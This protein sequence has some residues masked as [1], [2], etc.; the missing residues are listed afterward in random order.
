MLLLSPQTVTVFRLAWKFI[1]SEDEKSSKHC[2]L[3]RLIIV[4]SN[5]KPL[6]SVDMHSVF[7]L[8]TQGLTSYLFLLGPYL[9]QLSKQMLRFRCVV[10][11]VTS[12][13]NEICVLFLVSD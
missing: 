10:P 1:A 4:I 11:S 2:Y 13:V 6:D 8:Y 5:H 3:L 7:A 9:V 12:E